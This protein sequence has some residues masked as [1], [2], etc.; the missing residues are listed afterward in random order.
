[1]GPLLSSGGM[2]K[3]SPFAPGKTKLRQNRG[4]SSSSSS[5][6]RRRRSSSDSSSSSSSNNNNNNNSGGNRSSRVATHPLSIKKYLEMRHGQEERKTRGMNDL[7]TKRKQMIPTSPY[8]KLL[9][10]SNDGDL[11]TRESSKHTK[12]ENACLPP[13]PTLSKY[14]TQIT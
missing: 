3:S 6:R 12:R 14:Q 11:D 4:H 8:N 10:T 9:Q 5:R 7:Q 13:S 1:M 2:S